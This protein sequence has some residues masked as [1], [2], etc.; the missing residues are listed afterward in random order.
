MRNNKYPHLDYKN[1]ILNRKIERQ[2]NVFKLLYEP[3]DFKYIITVFRWK[4]GYWK[5]HK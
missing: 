1:Y 4:I 3:D 5:Q 2:Q